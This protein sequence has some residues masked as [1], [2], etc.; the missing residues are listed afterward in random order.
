MGKKKHLQVPGISEDELPLA[1]LSDLKNNIIQ[2]LLNPQN[3]VYGAE[4]FGSS[5]VIKIPK[6]KIHEIVDL[7]IQVG[8][9]KSYM[10]YLSRAS[11]K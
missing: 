4:A 2:G 8:L 11:P 10:N 1:V 7:G 9:K 5:E 3:H 6:E